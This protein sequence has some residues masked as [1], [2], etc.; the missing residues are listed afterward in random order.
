AP[1]GD[2]ADDQLAVFSID[3]HALVL[4]PTPAPVVVELQ[5][6]AVDP[7]LAAR[8]DAPL[9]RAERRAVATRARIAAGRV[10]SAAPARSSTADVR[11][12]GVGAA[13]IGSTGTAGVR[14]ATRGLRAPGCAT[15]ATRTRV[16]SG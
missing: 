12:A 6:L 11:A 16:S 4:V 2:R 3:D 14:A 15:R 1:A 7:V 9:V 13:S 8:F 5:E 10:A